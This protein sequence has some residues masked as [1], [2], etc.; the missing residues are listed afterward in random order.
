M[1]EIG[2]AIGNPLHGER[3]A[4]TVGQPFAGVEVRLVDTPLPV[5]LTNGAGSY[6]IPDVPDGFQGLAF[7]TR[8]DLVPDAR[9]V[10]TT[11]G[12]VQLDF[13][14][15]P[16][17]LDFEA[18]SGTLTGFTVG[19]DPTASG[20]EFIMPPLDTSLGSEP[21]AAMARYAFTIEQGGDYVLWARIHA[22]GYLADVG[23]HFLADVGD[24]VDERDLGG[25]EGVGGVL[26][27]L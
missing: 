11:P 17:Q 26:D 23:A 9:E 13:R 5:A 16:P 18:E 21:G 2:M 27:Q 25:Q 15:V 22:P 14:L 10:S 24:L 1:T 4:G 3:R 6:V 20:G 12:P 7:A 19:R 8:S